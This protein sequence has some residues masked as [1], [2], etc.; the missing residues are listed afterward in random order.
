MDAEKL[1]VA[2]DD[3]NSPT[4]EL[5]STEAVATA[6]PAPGLALRRN[7][8]WRIL[9][10]P[11]FL[12]CCVWMRLR[13]S[14]RENVDDSRGG[15]LLVNHQSFLDPMLVAVLLSRPISYLARDSLFKLP[16][17]GWIL[18]NTHVIPISRES[19]RG[20][21]IRIAIERLNEGFLVGIFPEGTRSADGTVG[22]FRPGFLALARRTSQPIYPVGIAGATRAMPRGAWFVRP[23]RIRVVYGTP[24][25]ADEVSQFH[26]SGDEAALCELVRAR[27]AECASKAAALLT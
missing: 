14:G 9:Q 5:E 3:L 6:L 23:C 22:R 19:A 17:V 10:L 8:V 21:S 13:V 20:G 1:K 18:R 15:L 16:V 11:F 24:F 4:A 25:S 2:A 12:S 26:S 27:V 7:P